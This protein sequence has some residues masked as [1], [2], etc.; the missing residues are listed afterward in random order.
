MQKQKHIA[1][2]TTKKPKQQHQN[3]NP[4]QQQD[5][6]EALQFDVCTELHMNACFLTQQRDA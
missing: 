1:L 6:S 2:R 3:P 5:R 4:N